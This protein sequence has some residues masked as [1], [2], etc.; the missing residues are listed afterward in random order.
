MNAFKTSAIAFTF[1]LLSAASLQAQSTTPKT[2]GTS[3]YRVQNS[4]KMRLSVEKTPGETVS[5]RLIDQ[6]GKELHRES[7]GRR[8]D[9]YGCYF[10]FSKVEDGDYTIEIA[11]GAEVE[12]KAIHLGSKEVVKAPARALV[13]LN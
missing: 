3:L 2:F 5:V 1:A 4:M 12:R 9:K 11:N 6:D 8:I 10:D 7:I 13:A